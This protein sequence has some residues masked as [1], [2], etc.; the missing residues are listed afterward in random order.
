VGEAVVPLFA[1]AH[2]PD[3]V[4]ALPPPSNG[5]V[6][7]IVP[8]IPIGAVKVCAAPEHAEPTAVPEPN[9]GVPGGGGL[10]PRIFSSVAPI[11]IPGGPTGEPGP[12][13]SGDVTPRGGFV[14]PICARAGVQ[15][16]TTAPTRDIV[17]LV[18]MV[19]LTVL[20]CQGLWAALPE[21][22]DLFDRQP[23]QISGTRE[24]PYLN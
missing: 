3:G 4:P 7:P 15:I 1:L 13:P 18:S 5:V 21:P 6:G 20:Q 19:L 24:R 11:G 16:R 23:P 14:S 12:M 10:T 17:I 9:V 2:V 8:P 22:W